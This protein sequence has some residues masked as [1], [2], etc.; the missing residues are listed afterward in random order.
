MGGVTTVAQN[1]IVL[2]LNA[3]EE[4][5]RVDPAAMLCPDGRYVCG[6]DE[7]IAQLV[8]RRL[9]RDLRVTIALPPDRVKDGTAVQI[10]EA[11]DRY[12]SLRRTQTQRD[13]AAQ[14]QDVMAAFRIGLVIFV[15]GLLLSYYF[16][17]SG[18]TDVTKLLLGDGFFPIIAWVGL[19]Y[20]FDA[21]VHY[22]RQTAREEKVLAFIE[23]MNVGVRPE[24][25][26]AA[27]AAARSI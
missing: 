18:L 25:S 9:D 6:M 26:A 14:W 15:A 10:R 24:P 4:L 27:T 19:W 11:V 23:R 20:P 22:R 17:K 7:L 5:F 3:P 2:R 21:I 12:C 13:R 8:P 1:E 16:A